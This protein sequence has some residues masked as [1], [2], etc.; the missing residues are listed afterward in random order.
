MMLA[1]K[2]SGI[3][4][5]CKNNRLLHVTQVADRVGDLGGMLL[6]DGLQAKPEAGQFYPWRIARLKNPNSGF[7]SSEVMAAGL[8]EAFICRSCGFTELYTR[9]PEAIEVDG[10]VVQA[11]DGPAAGAP[12]R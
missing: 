12:Y 6:D 3:C 7:F 8:V 2:T 9:D 4:P 10:Q 11:L 5:K 1:M